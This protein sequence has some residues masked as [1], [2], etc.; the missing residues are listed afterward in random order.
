[1][2]SAVRLWGEQGAA[3]G[4]ELPDFF[5][6]Q[7]LAD[8]KFRRQTGLAQKRLRPP[9]DQLFMGADFVGRQPAAA[10][11]ARVHSSGRRRRGRGRSGSRGAG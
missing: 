3:H 9:V 10:L 11:I 6:D 1:M 8:P 7:R 2:I 5:V 4:L